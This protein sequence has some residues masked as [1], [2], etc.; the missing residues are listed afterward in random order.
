[1]NNSTRNSGRWLLPIIVIGLL[2]WTSAVIAAPKEHANKMSDVVAAHAAGHGPEKVDVIAIFRNRPSHIEKNQVESHGANVKRQFSVIPAM[3]MEIP[4]RALK[5]LANNP[6]V[7]F[8]ALD[9]PMTSA[10]DT[11]LN[12]P[13]EIVGLKSS[14]AHQTIM[15]L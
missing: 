11:S 5:A 2:L 15:F 1:M 7:S 12:A 10:A 14:I 9:A 8:I 3:A 6:A 4:A 13:R